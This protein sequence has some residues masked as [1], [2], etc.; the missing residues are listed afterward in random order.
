MRSFVAS[1]FVVALSAC[2]PQPAAISIEGAEA[3]TVHK[4]D[5]VPLPKADVLD[6]AGAAIAPAPAIKWTVE[7]ADV[8]KIDEAA[9]QVVPLKDG[10]ATITATLGEIKKSF[11]VVV[12]LPDTLA[13]DGRDV[14]RTVKIGETLAV[15]AKV[16]A[17]GTE[18][19]EQ[20]FTFT[21]SDPNLATVAADGTVTGVAAGEV[22]IEAKS[23]ELKDA[24][25]VT[26][27]PSDAPAVAEPAMD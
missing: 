5:A 7:P 20:A 18:L 16:T 24:V 19:K 15:L 8:A 23:G 26:I 17:D 14:P 25:K 4:L 6:S 13:I 1:L 10:E 3:V 12:S 27:A 22:T 9:K 11:K 21:T 2:A